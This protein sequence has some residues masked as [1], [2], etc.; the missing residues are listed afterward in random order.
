M[1]V[2]DHDRQPG[3]NGQG[4][5][6]VQPAVVLRKVAYR[7][8]PLLFLLYVV[9]ILDRNNVAFARLRMLGDLGIKENAFGL[10]AGIFY[11]GYFALEVPSN[12]V[13][14]RIGARAWIGRIMISWGL[15]SIG[16]MFVVGPVSFGFLRF[17]LGIA[18]AGFFP[19][20]IYYLSCWFPTRDRARM[21]AW[22]M[23]A[24]PFTGVFGSP[25]SGGI[26]D[27]V[28]WLG[29]GTRHFA[30]LADWQWLFLV[31]G[32]PAVILGVVVILFLTDRPS[33]AHWLE[34]DER[35]WLAGLL[36]EEEVER[37]KRHGLTFTQMLTNRRVWL[38]C[39][40]YFA[41]SVSVNTFGLYV[42]ELMNQSFQG[43]SGFK[44]GCLVAL[45]CLA[46]VAGMVINGFHS[47]RTRERVWHTA[48]PA[49]FSVVGWAIAVFAPSPWVMVLGFTIAYMAMMSM[50]PPFWSL[51]TAF[52]S[53][54]AAA[55]GIAFINSVGNL[56]GFA[57]QATF[58]ALREATG[59]FFWGEVLLGLVMLAC[60]LLTLMVKHEGEAGEEMSH[61]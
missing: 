42:P 45:P 6:G 21:V 46:A 15:V 5:F 54:A 4:S 34:A 29:D 28:N 43:S 53:G 44:I 12:L 2:Q 7:L 59:S 35:A 57:G 52:L 61:R 38:L 26:L 37:E 13:L 56:G 47:D 19:G 11:L 60:G 8:L 50:L 27:L 33:D 39:A 48:G 30:G 14:R 36:Q 3:D 18:E 41:V 40:I 51:P 22:F 17:L 10:A 31:E 24:S 16:M 1:S 32:I 25:L 20:I 55:G 9:N 58:G 23:I 49:L